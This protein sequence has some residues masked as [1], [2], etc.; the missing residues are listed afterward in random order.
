MCSTRLGIK[1]KRLHS[2]K[3]EFLIILNVTIRENDGIVC[4]GL[5]TEGTDFLV[6]RLNF[7]RKMGHDGSCVLVRGL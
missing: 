7:R 4:K 5:S 2:A 6:I 1:I 3:R